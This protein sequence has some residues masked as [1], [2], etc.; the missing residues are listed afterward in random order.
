M[1]HKLKYVL[2]GVLSERSVSSLWNFLSKY[3]YSNTKLS[4]F[5]S[6]GRV[7]RVI[8]IS[9]FSSANF[10]PTLEKFPRKILFSPFSIRFFIFP[11]IIAQ[12]KIV[13]LLMNAMFPFIPENLSKEKLFCYSSI[14]FFHSRTKNCPEKKLFSHIS[15][16]FFHFL[17]RKYSNSVLLPLSARFYEF[18]HQKYLRKARNKQKSRRACFWCVRAEKK[19]AKSNFAELKSKI[20]LSNFFNVFYFT[21]ASTCSKCSHKFCKYFRNY[22][23][24]VCDAD[25]SLLL[26]VNKINSQ[27]DRL[28]ISRESTPNLIKPNSYVLY[29]F[30]F[31]ERVKNYCRWNTL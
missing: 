4:P 23:A 27:S 17:S 28:K 2:A 13:S 30:L 25:N 6:S 1:K 12:K 21:L 24:I 5:N 16:R 29:F 8:I 26:T 10:L 19:N 14:Q 22:T 15:V 31:L 20:L 18:P 3:V 7:W 9:P 11:R